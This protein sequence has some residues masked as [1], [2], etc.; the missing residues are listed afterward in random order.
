MRYATE[1]IIINPQ[2]PVKQ[3]GHLQQVNP[4]SKVNDDLSAHIFA[5]ETENNIF[6]NISCDV[7]GFT[8]D[9][10]EEIK[11]QVK[12]AFDKD[13]YL[14]LS[15]THTHY[16]GDTTDKTYHQQLI[17]QIVQAIKQ[18][19]FND[20][21]LSYTYR[22]VPYEEVGTSRISNH[23]ALVIL[24]LLEIF[25]N[26]QEIINIINYN[27]HPT[28]LSADNTDFFSAEYVGYCLNLLNEENKCFNTFWQGAAGDVS[29]RFTRKGQTYDDVK[30][31]GTK[32]FNKIEQLKNQPATHYPLNSFTLTEKVIPVN[33]DLN[34]IDLS[35]LPKNLSPR[36]MET[37]GFGKIMRQK[38]QNHQRV[39]QKEMILTKLDL[40]HVKI[41]FAPNELFSYY[42]SLVNDHNTIL[43]CYSN[44]Y[45]PYVTPINEM[46]LTYETFL[47]VLDHQTKQELVDTLKNFAG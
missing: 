9:Y 8:Y 36:E 1:K 2:H 24:N 12:N 28:I 15:A 32:L 16:S 34:E 26:D 43:V 20:G 33:I 41:I 19:H 31:L 27:C 4:V 22:S 3:A 39:L 10:T 30:E 23:K 5:L 35:A 37:I 46:L 38:I 17:G 21:N 45:S 40:K 18:L 25:D 44:G 29:C 13:I 6:I 7:L 47:D 11:K 14:V 42:L